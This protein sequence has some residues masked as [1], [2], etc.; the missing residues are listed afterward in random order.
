MLRSGFLDNP[1]SLSVRGHVVSHPFK[2]PSSD[3]LLERVAHLFHTD[4][5][6]STRD[7]RIIFLC[8][9]P[10]GGSGAGTSLRSRFLQYASRY[11]KHYRIFLAEAAY[12]NYLNIET[13]E[14]F[15]VAD[16]ESI[17]ADISD[18][19]V[20][21]P[22]SPGSYSEAGFFSQSE[23]IRK[24]V[25]IVNNAKMQSVDS[26]LSIG[27]ID[28]FNSYSRFKSAIYIDYDAIKPRFLDI[29]KRIENRLPTK[30]REIFNFDDEFSLSTKNQ[31]YLL[32]ELVT[33]LKATTIEGLEYVL[34]KSF[35]NTDF[36][37]YKQLLSILIAGDY[38]SFKG[39]NMEFLVSVAGK[40]GFLEF[41][42][43]ATLKRMSTNILVHYKVNHT[44]TFEFVRGVLKK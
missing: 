37:K 31:L 2:H 40:G 7:R 38:L 29:K 23:E 18:C 12:K 39:D 44:K 5:I 32:F 25:L 4:G 6:Y 41:P 14:F 8:G 19:V 1:P 11:M 28:L 10:V 42:R 24:K 15:N 17:L 3:V 34:E 35:M 20:L 22:E 16:F 27:P 26:F 9:G 43:P 21:F 30:Q 33:I 13:E 36:S